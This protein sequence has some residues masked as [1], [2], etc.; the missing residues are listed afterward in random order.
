MTNR[1][2]KQ[3]FVCL[4]LFVAGC[5]ATQ[6]NTITQVSTIDAILAGAYDGQMTCEELL[7]YGDFGIGTFD[8]LDGEMILLD[9]TL[10]QVRYDGSVCSP[11]H[12][13]TT[14]FASVVAFGADISKEVQGG[15]DYE[16]LKALVNE[17]VPNRN[18][19]C[20][21]KI[22]GRFSALRTRSVP[23]QDKPYPP[24][25]EVTKHQPLFDLNNLS[26]TI[27]G[28]R[29]PAYVKGIG[30]PG[31][32]LHFISDDGK[33]GGHVLQFALEEGTAEIDICNRLLMILPAGESDFSRIDLTLDRSKDLEES[34]R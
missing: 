6:P 1:S 30:V 28:F 22:P 31:Y 2:L 16:G 19:F 12:S 14:P 15:M 7:S 20:A 8:R 10:Y 29:S 9:G 26:G 21:V 18:V 17:A 13:L 4:I 27:V 24:L 33:S 3:F 23:P 25:A 11:T 34:E 32:H 5:C